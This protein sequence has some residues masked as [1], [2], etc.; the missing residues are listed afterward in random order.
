MNLINVVMQCHTDYEDSWATPILVTTDKDKAEAKVKEMTDR[1]LVRNAAANA[2]MAHMEAWRAA[3]PRPNVV[4]FKE[5]ALPNY[6][7]KRHKWSP[8]QLAEYK[9]AKDHNQA[10]H[11][12]ALQPMHEWAQRNLSE[13][14]RF[15]STFS[16]DVQNDVVNITEKSY[17]EIE[18]VPWE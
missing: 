8:E 10:G 4:A 3:N 9:S 7:S 2:T 6:G 1:Q 14:R 11:A 16:Q 15:N 13:N 18:E 5:K 12:A 17:W